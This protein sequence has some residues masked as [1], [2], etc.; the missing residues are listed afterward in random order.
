MNAQSTSLSS[1]GFCSIACIMYTCWC[2]H[3]LVCSPERRNG[4]QLLPYPIPANC[5]EPVWKEYTICH[6]EM[7]SRWLL[8]TVKG[9]HE[10]GSNS[11]F[12]EVA[13]CLTLRSLTRMKLWVCWWFVFP[14]M[15]SSRLVFPA[16]SQN[17]G[18][19]SCIISLGKELCCIFSALP[20]PKIVP[21]ADNK[22]LLVSVT[23]TCCL[24]IKGQVVAIKVRNETFRQ[25]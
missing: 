3:G 5:D 20:F 19:T 13:Y 12:T 24:I 14:L 15:F 22:F 10:L 11:E 25:I 9:D 1:Y 18:S 7:G 17:E 4:G 23:T 16:A 21:R 2:I 8:F 6:Q